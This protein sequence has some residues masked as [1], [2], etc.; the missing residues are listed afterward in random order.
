MA[1]SMIAT[2]KRFS[3]LSTDSWPL[4]DVPEGSTFHVIDTGEEYIFHNGTWELDRRQARALEG[5]LY[6]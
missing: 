5:V 6:I 3:G 4:T 1:V 2:I